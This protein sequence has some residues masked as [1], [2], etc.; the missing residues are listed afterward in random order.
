MTIRRYAKE[1]GPM[2]KVVREECINVGKRMGTRLWKAKQDNVIEKETK[3]GKKFR[4]CVL[5][6]VEKQSRGDQ[7]M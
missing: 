7:C 6:G 5:G 3:T 2:T 1:E 4:Q